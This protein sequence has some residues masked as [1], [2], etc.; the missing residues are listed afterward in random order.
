VANRFLKTLRE[1]ARTRKAFLVVFAV[2][3]LLVAGTVVVLAGIPPPIPVD[4]MM[5]ADSRTSTPRVTSMIVSGRNGKKYRY[6]VDA[7][8]RPYVVTRNGVPW[9]TILPASGAVEI[10]DPNGVPSVV[11]IKASP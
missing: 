8:T 5:G 11:V 10:R 7:S 6:H 3:G 4:G 9:F 2:I 1:W